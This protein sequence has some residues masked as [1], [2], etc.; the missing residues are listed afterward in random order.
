MEPRAIAFKGSVVGDAVHLNPMHPRGRRCQSEGC[1]TFLSVYN[2]GPLCWKHR[3]AEY[4]S[5]DRSFAVETCDV[6]LR[7][8]R[9]R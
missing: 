2:A 4:G 1:A 7:R 3:A 9:R 6:S 8:R 5:P